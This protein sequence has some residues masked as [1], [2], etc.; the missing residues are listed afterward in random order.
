M[1]RNQASVRS[2]ESWAGTTTRFGCGAVSY[3]YA[4]STLRPPLASIAPVLSTT[5]KSSNW[6]PAC[7]T[8]ASWKA[9]HGPERSMTFT[10][11]AIAV[12]TNPFDGTGSGWSGRTAASD[13]ARLPL[14][15]EGRE[16]PGNSGAYGKGREAASIHV[17]SR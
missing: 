4:A 10:P 16:G 11:G 6:P 14:Q 7:A 2:L 13:S 3:E 9:S 17:G 8:A 1:R 5:V 12:R 15:A